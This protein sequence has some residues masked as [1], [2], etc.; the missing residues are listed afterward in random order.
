MN[1]LYT[2]HRISGLHLSSRIVMAPMTRARAAQPG[3]VPSALMAHYYAQRAS[4]GLIISEAT[5][6]SPQGQGYSFAPGIHSDAQIMGWR[7]V[8][9]A[10]HEA[11]GRMFLQLWHVGRM[12]HGSFHADGKPVAPSA[13]AP[14]AEVWVVNS[15]TGAGQMLECPTPRALSTFEVKSIVQDFKQAARNALLAGFDG[16]EIHG[17]NGYLI[18]QFLRASSNKRDDRYG[19]SV[20]NRIRFAVEIAEHVSHVFGAGRVGFRLSPFNMSRGMDDPSAPDT[21]IALAKSLNAMALGYIHIA[22]ADWDYAP[23]TPVSFRR[24]LRD[25]FGGT[26]IVAGNYN[27]EKSEAI[28]ASGH[29]DLVAFGRPFIANPDLP[30]R[31]MNGAALSPFD[32]STLFGGSEQGYTSYQ[33]LQA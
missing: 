33:P 30:R 29:A 15:Q 17:A 20:H 31:L 4:A 7:K 16:V 24:A 6:V 19:G 21:M 18:D 12:S 25:A 2:P 1:T 10:V 32:P 8:T 23:E 14:N 28:L 22:E 13:I 9:D 5:Q 11:G 26:I 3:N 27:A